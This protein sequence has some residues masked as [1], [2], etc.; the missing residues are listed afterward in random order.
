MPHFHLPLQSGDDGVLHRMGRRYVSADYAATV[1]RVRSAVPGVA[2]HGD[3]IVG[4]PTEDDAAWR[5]SYGFIESIDFAGV[6]VF[7]YSARPGTPALRMARQVDEPTRK[8][9]A[10]ELLTLAADAKARW[11]RGRIGS[12]ASVLF[13]SRL[14]DGR[15][16]GHAADHAMVAAQP[17]PGEGL[18]NVVGRVRV[19]SVDPSVQDR[20][21]GRLVGTVPPPRMAPA[22]GSDAR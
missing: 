7:R 17:R 22:G 16:V 6:H 1:G 11:A 8:A 10:G 5:R 4:F 20:V 19:E 3:V 12:E 21:V 9:R 2:I 13:E 15:W 18:E 14:D